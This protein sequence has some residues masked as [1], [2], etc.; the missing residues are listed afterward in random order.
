[1][2]SLLVNNSSSFSWRSSSS[3]DRASASSLSKSKSHS[4]SS[5]SSSRGN[6]D[7]NGGIDFIIDEFK[8]PESRDRDS[9]DEN[10]RIGENEDGFA[11]EADNDAN[12]R[13]NEVDDD[14]NF[15]LNENEANVLRAQF[16]DK[17]IIINK[18]DEKF[19]PYLECLLELLTLK[20]K[21]NIASSHLD[22]F[23]KFLKKWK[24]SV[25]DSNGEKQSLPKNTAGIFKA[26]GMNGPM[27]DWH[28][29]RACVQRCCILPKNA[30]F[31]PVVSCKEPTSDQDIVFHHRK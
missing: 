31:C 12:D 21:S 27:G 19:D 24:F 9:S 8:P 28:T 30:K 16:A 23:I 10:D 4:R 13:D 15:L 22:A 6:Y 5:S 7:D 2:P 11:T 3:A 20:M 17:E 25:K 14:F 26:L 1:M 29:E 18:K